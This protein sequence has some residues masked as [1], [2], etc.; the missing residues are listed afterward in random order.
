MSEI[1][2]IGEAVTGGMAA[3]AVEPEHGETLGRT[4]ETAC[5]NCCTRLAGDYCHRCGQHAHV[6]RTLGAF[7]H[8]FLH[9]VLH[10]E[11]KIIRTLPK[12]MLRPGELT[13]RYIAGER[14]RFVSPL[15]LFLF[16]VFLM[17]AVM[18]LLGSPMNMIDEA[19][20]KTASAELRRE[21]GEIDARLLQLQRDKVAA[22]A[23]GAPTTSIDEDIR[24]VQKARELLGA[25]SG[26][27]KPPPGSEA[28]RAGRAVGA[29]AGGRDRPEI[30]VPGVTIEAGDA[31]I[32]VG[33]K[34]DSPLDTAWKAAKKNPKLLIYKVQTNAYKFSWALI[35]IS[36]PFVAL[37]FL[38]R[39]RPLYDHAVFVT[40]SISAMSVLTILGSLLVLAGVP[41]EPVWLAAMLFVPWHMYRQLRGG[42]EL[43]RFSAL[44]RTFFLLIFAFFASLL[45]A[46]GLLMLGL[47]G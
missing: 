18:S 30:D 46:I 33:A 4:H 16:S 25:M 45:F 1:G 19:E 6:H 34:P 2:G 26:E 28:Y 42:Y 15:A 36:V 11:G 27:E 21:V 5:L 17:F 9:G 3:R 47:L 35:L 29:A 41:S 24:G 7:G 14:A 13:R 43:R 39:R 38:W 32:G 12:L 37:L 31:E 22:V 10:L 40:Y 44:W 8:D 20:R 23:R